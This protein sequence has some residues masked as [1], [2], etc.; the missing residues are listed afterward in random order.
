M[1]YM[2]PLKVHSIMMMVVSRSKYSIQIF[3][4]WMH[5]VPSSEVSLA[6]SGTEGVESGGF[7]VG[8]MS[9]VDVGPLLALY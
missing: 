3:L 1:R 4:R 2:Q 7:R 9:R 6:Y 8:H 5:T